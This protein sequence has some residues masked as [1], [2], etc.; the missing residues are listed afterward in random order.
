MMPVRKVSLVI[1]IAGMLMPYVTGFLG[2]MPL[3]Q[4]IIFEAGGRIANG[5]LPFRDFYLPYGLVPALM[6]S[7]FFKLL[8]VS[9]FAYVTHAALINGLFALLVFDSLRMLMPSARTTALV[10]GSLLAAWS[11]YPMTGTPFLEN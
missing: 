8:G 4:S 6:Q 2:L 11:F 9:W 7:V 1:F 3:D 5:E 10:A